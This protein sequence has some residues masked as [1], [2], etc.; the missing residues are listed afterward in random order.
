MANV[1][2]LSRM[3]CKPERVREFL[4]LCRRIEDHARANEP[5]TELFKFFKLR[6]ANRYVVLERFDDEAAESVHMQSTLLAEVGP[7][8][9]DCLDGSWE[10]EYF[11]DL[12]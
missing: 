7:K 2:F 5:G 8:I 4:S 11:D 12:E 10:R 9:A 3:T 6:E 1:T